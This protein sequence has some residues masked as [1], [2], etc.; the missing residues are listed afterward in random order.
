[1]NANHAHDRSH[2]VQDVRNADSV[3]LDIFA[4][5]Q[6][7]RR[8]L[9]FVFLVALVFV[10]GTA[11][12]SL[13]LTPIYQATTQVL[14]DPTVRQPFDDP[15]SPTRI[16]QGTELIDSQISVIQSDAVLRPVVHANNLAKDPVFGTQTSPGVLSGLF[17]FLHASSDARQE[18]LEAQETQSIEALYKATSVKR[19]GQ[20]YVINISVES[21]NPTQ[22]AVLS[23]AIAESYLSDQSRQI[24][25][26]SKE[27]AFQIDDRLISLRERLRQAESEIQKFRAQNKL[28]SSAEGRL[29]TEQELAGLNT[30]LIAAR[31]SLAEANAKYQQIQN[32][33][34]Q[35]IDAEAIGDVVNSTTISRLREQYAV[36]ARNEADL[37]AD[38][39]PSHPSVLRARSQ[40]NRIRSLIQE[41][42]K[43]IAASTKIDVQVNQERVA[44]LQR[45]IDTARTMS[46]VDET[47]SI[48]L[49]ELETEAQATRALYEVALGKAKEISELD[50]V[51]LPNVRIITPAVAPDSPDWPK[52]KIMVLLAGILGMLVGTG[53][54]VGGEAI[55]IA[56]KRLIP[57]ISE[58]TFHAP[59]IAVD[60]HPSPGPAPKRAAET[61]AFRKRMRSIP[62]A[63]TDTGFKAISD[64][65]WLTNGRE[66][67]DIKPLTEEDILAV[68]DAVDQ[69]YSHLNG[70]NRHFGQGIDR[71]LQGVL[72]TPETEGTRIVF[73]TSPDF[74][75]GQTITAFAL[76]LGAARR[77]F[78]VLLADAEP[79]QRLLSN[80]LSLDDDDYNGDLRHRVVDYDE[81]GISFVSLVAGK[82]KY[83]RQCVDIREALE[84]ARLCQD[85]DLV[86]IDG[87]ALPLLAEGDSLAGLSSAFV[88]TISESKESQFSMPILADEISTL[89]K[90]K[91][92][93]FVRTMTNKSP[94]FH[95]TLQS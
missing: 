17:G 82:P 67:G 36:A 56:K 27:A 81:L 29:L 3:A 91:P 72:Q 39:L 84:F 75:Q 37:L 71:I 34:K 70:P 48:K 66:I 25:R 44:N 58:E 19:V 73:F 32:I 79:N 2:S 6:V 88:V 35:G 93:A 69:Y 16:G 59:P 30:S 26:A 49:R 89:T 40:L 54:A 83:K 86:I 63:G 18:S 31:T 15:N 90:G 4:I 77:S 53:L 61:E 92:T 24:G 85:Y 5:I 14:F 1:M 46:D 60:V 57:P 51:V 78:R 20:S 87:V 12:L 52:K 23:N 65:A 50:Q 38:L 13:K 94:S 10:I 28:Q 41:E 7:L 43:R 11:V 33:L 47:A 22:A 42:V 9:L 95:H 74:G 80:D 8:R 76:A 64:L 55:E 21:P 45:Q 68:Q 62:V